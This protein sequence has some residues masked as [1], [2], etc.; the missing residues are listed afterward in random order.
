[1]VPYCSLLNPHDNVVHPAF[2]IDDLLADEAVMSALENDA[3]AVID[4]QPTSV[5]PAPPSSNPS[6]VNKDTPCPFR[7]YAPCLAIVDQSSSDMLSCCCNCLIHKDVQYYRKPIKAILHCLSV[8]LASLPSVSTCYWPIELKYGKVDDFLAIE[9]LLL[10]FIEHGDIVSLSQLSHTNRTF[11]RLV[12]D[13]LTTRLR[14]SLTTFIP[15]S[16]LFEFFTTLNNNKACIAGS[17]ALRTLTPLSDWTPEDLNIIIPAGSTAPWHMF[18]QYHG[19]QSLNTIDNVKYHR[20]QMATRSVSIYGHPS[21]EVI[22]TLSLHAI[23]KLITYL[24][25]RKLS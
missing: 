3:I 13:T 2:S 7:K 12:R 9:E 14:D 20:Y 19:F 15:R 10:Q 22:I 23:D 16:I 11:R 1:M 21:L 4:I 17:V 25:R 5:T 6:K 24:C 8:A 18:F